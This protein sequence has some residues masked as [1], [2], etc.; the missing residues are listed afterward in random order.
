MFNYTVTIHSAD[1]RELGRWEEIPGESRDDAAGYVRT[2]TRLP[3]GAARLVVRLTGVRRS[4]P[5]T[6]AELFALGVL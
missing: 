1:G 6:D 5:E 2:F 3:A 4:D